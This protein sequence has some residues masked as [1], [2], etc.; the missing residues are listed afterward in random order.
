[1]RWGEERCIDC[2]NT[3]IVGDLRSVL[4]KGHVI[5]QSVGGNLYAYNEC[6]RCNERFGHGAE[7]ALVGDPA[8]RSAA[9]TIA[10]QIPDLIRRM[11]RRKDFLAQSDTGVLVRARFDGGG[12]LKIHQT[13]QADGSRTASD[14]DIRME[15]ETTL[16]RRG[17]AQD[18]IA[19]EL[20]R[21]DEAPAETPVSIGGFVIR[22]GSAEG[23]GLLPYGDPIVRD[24]A[25]LAIA[26]RYLATC[27]GG[28]IYGA[29]FDAIREAIRSN[30]LPMNGVWRVESYG[31]RERT[32]EPWHGL[33]IK[34]AQP[35]VVVYVR[36]FGALIWLVHFEQ[37]PL[38]EHRCLP[39]R[40]DLTDGS[41]SVGGCDAS[42]ST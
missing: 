15:I 17:L 28:L 29:P 16:R 22:K 12:N 3:P 32:P 41:E 42:V 5:P 36:L 27:L 4:T 23:F 40:I 24:V 35:H 25:L 26:Y 10:D 7:A 34:E 19:E 20:R 1:M 18:Q 9:E 31:T 39:Y 37:I 6:K 13:H 33:A 21:L 30:D 11:R 8:V 2:L 14:A 38:K